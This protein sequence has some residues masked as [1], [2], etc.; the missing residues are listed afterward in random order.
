VEDAAGFLQFAG[1]CFRHKRK[2][3]RNNLIGHY[4]KEVA[5]ALPEGG[6]RA[7]QLSIEQFIEL[8]QRIL[9]V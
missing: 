1:A 8:Y 7:E 5:D 3:L 9:K 4:G 2:T 6:L